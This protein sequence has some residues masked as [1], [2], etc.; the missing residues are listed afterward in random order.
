MC[1]QKNLGEKCRFQFGFLGYYYFPE[2]KRFITVAVLKLN[3]KAYECYGRNIDPS[4]DY[5][6]RCDYPLECQ[7]KGLGWT[8]TFGEKLINETRIDIYF[9]EMKDTV[10]IEVVNVELNQM[11]A[12]LGG[13]IGC[14]TGFSFLTTIEIVEIFFLLICILINKRIFSS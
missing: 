6:R 8:D 7:E 1:K 11:I 9:D 3:E 2:M 13:L 5:R 14:F 10:I 4:E 12:N